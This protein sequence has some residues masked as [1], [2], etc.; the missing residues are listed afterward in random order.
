ML[1]SELFVSRSGARFLET[2]DKY[3]RSHEMMLVVNMIDKEGNDITVYQEELQKI[4]GHRPLEDYYT[5]FISAKDKQRSLEL[6]N[7]A[8]R[9]QRLAQRSKFDKFVINLNNFVLNRRQRAHLTTPLTRLQVLMRKIRFRTDHDKEES[10]LDL[11]MS[12]LERASCEVKHAYSDFRD[13]M[14]DATD[15]TAGT[16]LNALENPPSDYNVFCQNQMERF[17]QKCKDCV[18]HLADTLNTYLEILHDE[19]LSIDESGLA[20]EVRDRIRVSD[21][22]RGIFASFTSTPRTMETKGAMSELI[23]SAQKLAEISGQNMPEQWTSAISSGNVIEATS[24]VL[25]MVDRNVVLKIGHRLGHKF[26][27]WEAVKLSTKLSKAVPLL[28]IA[29]TAWEV[30]SHRRERRKEEKAALELRQFKTDVK[31]TLKQNSDEIIRVVYHE[32]VDNIE[33]IITGGLE[34]V[35]TKKLE[36]STYAEHHRECCK[37]LEVKRAQCMYLYDEIYGTSVNPH[38]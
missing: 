16:I 34:L 20:E 28:N 38:C 27:P 26:K 7:P 3:K 33:K 4:L 18:T 14:N 37:E 13:E 31:S 32:L 17:E 9:R 35:R 29:A 19:N 10:L 25:K 23:T 21:E 12:A 1:T 8:E 22:L 15:S 36:L 30:E 5:T 24:N 2:L 6:Q 11:R